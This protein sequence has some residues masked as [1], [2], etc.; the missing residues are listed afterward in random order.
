ME[1]NESDMPRYQHTQ[2][3]ALFRDYATSAICHKR[4]FCM[5]TRRRDQ[6]GLGRVLDI[7]SPHM[8]L[9]P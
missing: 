8:K 7:W 9:S 1:L 5:H 3:Q 6:P 2:N 4:T